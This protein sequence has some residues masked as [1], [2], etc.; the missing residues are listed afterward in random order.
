LRLGTP[1]RVYRRLGLMIGLAVLFFL[2]YQAQLYLGRLERHR[3]P[4]ALEPVAHEGALA[5]AFTADGRTLVS[6]DAGGRLKRWNLATGKHEAQSLAGRSF[7]R[8]DARELFLDQPARLC[9][10]TGSDAVYALPLKGEAGE[11]PGGGLAAWRVPGLVHGR[12]SDRGRYLFGPAF[13]ETSVLVYDAASLSLVA[14]SPASAGLLRAVDLSQDGRWLA[15]FST[16]HDLGFETLEAV[17]LRDGTGWRTLDGQWRGSPHLTFSPD[18]RYLGLL[19]GQETQEFQL[20]EAGT[21]QVLSRFRTE[22][23]KM[24]LFRFSPDGR[25]IARPVRKRRE[26]V[27]STVGIERR[28]EWVETV[29]IFEVSTGRARF[30][31]QNPADVR[32]H[33]GFIRTCAWSPDGARLATLGE[34]SR[35]ALWDAKN[36]R[37]L[38]FLAD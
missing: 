19:A 36:A 30:S 9:V 37:F 22:A 8:G 38:R 11:A 33:S 12:P 2:I 1:P 18:S 6:V 25:L 35:I 3:R 24:P 27:V 32:G 7:Y 26:Y 17:D 4:A 13:G 31:W 21:W 29:Q 14:R 28:R 16:R 20:R 5:V 23:S 10:V 15:A 34:D